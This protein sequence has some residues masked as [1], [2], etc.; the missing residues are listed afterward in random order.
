MRRLAR[1]IILATLVQLLGLGSSVA[2]ASTGYAIR[3]ADPDLNSG[4]KA[5]IDE[6][7]LKL[8][9]AV[10]AELPATLEFQLRE[11]KGRPAEVVGDKIYLRSGLLATYLEDA[12]DANY[13]RKVAFSRHPDFHTFMVAMILHELSHILD[14]RFQFSSR[15]DFDL[16]HFRHAYA[17][18]NS[19]NIDNQSGPP[20]RVRGN[21]FEGRSVD[22]YEFKNP[23][24]AF[25][26]GFEFFVLDPNFK[27]RRPQHFEFYR[28]S[29]GWSTSAKGCAAFNK[30]FYINPSLTSD[31]AFKPTIVSPKGKLYAVH[32]LV[33]GAGKGAMSR[34]GHAMLRLVY[35]DPDRTIASEQCLFDVDQHVVITPAAAVMDLEISQFDGLTGKYPSSF[36]AALL[37]ATTQLYNRIEERELFSIPLKL[38]PAQLVSVE[39]AIHESH[40]TY[41]NK[42]YFTVNNC[43]T[44]VLNLIKRAMPENAAVQSSYSSTPFSLLDLFKQLGLAEDKDL[45][46]WRN[47]STKR[48]YF[49][50]ATKTLQFLAKFAADNMKSPEVVDYMKMTGAE[51]LRVV[52]RSKQVTEAKRVGR[53]LAALES[54][55][56]MKL[57]LEVFR[58]LLRD[59]NSRSTLKTANDK[60]QSEYQS[61]FAPPTVLGIEHYGL[62]S[63]E[64]IADILTARG[65]TIESLN[66]DKS[67]MF[68]DVKKSSDHTLQQKLVLESEGILKAL[69]TP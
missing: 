39:Q 66:K 31:E 37:G 43:A 57:Q 26:V 27:C 2:S 47:D 25:A 58:A 42:Y 7:L 41:R 16:L 36:F 21:F 48:F 61:W 49:P 17:Q 33:A 10:Q 20:Q 44:E 69:E 18:D 65:K 51:R 60:I 67:S 53:A 3:V 64:E 24:E 8:P 5:L 38:T 32:Y 28:R 12:S 29:F 50:P 56:M 23:K 63:D 4:Y 40:W 19:S 9:A 59:A 14:Q 62:P 1:S 6:A 52:A 54:N 45:E 35:C 13:R 15:E 55:L 30:H 11:G 34:F 46:H 22:P 68:S